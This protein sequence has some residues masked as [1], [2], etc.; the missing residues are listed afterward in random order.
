MLMSNSTVVPGLNDDLVKYKKKSLWWEW[1][2]A[3]DE[4]AD[5]ATNDPLAITAGGGSK[6]GDERNGTAVISHRTELNA[7]DAKG[8]RGWVEEEVEE[9]EEMVC[10]N[11]QHN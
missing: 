10:T 8:K 11:Q 1:N 6:V 3:R 4:S 9:K 7:A 5:E 2:H